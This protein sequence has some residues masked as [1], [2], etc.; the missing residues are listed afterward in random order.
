MNKSHTQVIDDE[1][2]D[3]RLRASLLHHK[4]MQLYQP[5]SERAEKMR[6][7][8]AEVEGSTWAQIRK[9]KSEHAALQAESVSQTVS[10]S[11][12]PLSPRSRSPRSRAAGSNERERAQMEVEANL[13][14]QVANL[15][16][17]NAKLRSSI[18]WA[19]PDENNQLTYHKLDT[20][21]EQIRRDLKH[22][23]EGG[24]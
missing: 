21:N 6:D 7:L 15:Q 17:E 23:I 9:L 3:L 2:K 8:T 14:R 5:S 12:A 22:G 16:A 10:R 1:L 11:V 24:G 19:D 4:Q 13:Q 20:E 18:V